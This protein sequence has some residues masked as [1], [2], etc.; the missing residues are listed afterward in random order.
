MTDNVVAIKDGRLNLSRITYL[1]DLQQASGQEIPLGVIAEIKIDSVHGL[2]LIARTELAE[3]ET[4]A[5]GRLIRDSLRNPFEFLKSEFDWAWTNASP[6]TALSKLAN[7]NSESLLFAP[8]TSIMI[9]RAFKSEGDVGEFARR[10]LRDRRD[11]EFDLMLA[12]LWG[13]ADSPTGDM[14]KMAA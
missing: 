14:A 6:G 4:S 10:E 3:H 7:R 1:C 5:I 2:G 13:K 8:P 12:E 9:R 11:V